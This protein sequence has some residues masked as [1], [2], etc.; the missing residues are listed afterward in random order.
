[1]FFIINRLWSSKLFRDVFYVM[2]RQFGVKILSFCALTYS[3]RVLGPSEIGLAGLALG[4]I[5][6]LGFVTQLGLDTILPQNLSLKSSDVERNV[7]AARLYSM[8]LSIVLMLSPVLVVGIFY[9]AGNIGVEFYKILSIWTAAF[10]LMVANALNPQLYIQGLGEVRSYSNIQL[11]VSVCSAVAIGILSFASPSIDGLNFLQSLAILVV[12]YL[13]Y[14]KNKLIGLVKVGWVSA[15]GV[16]QHVR[17]AWPVI[18]SGFAIYLIGG[19]EVLIMPMVSTVKQVG[20]YNGGMAI[21]AGVNAFL[22]LA[23]FV[24]YP[25]LLAWNKIGEGFAFNRVQLIAVG[26]LIIS[27]VFYFSISGV[28]NKY[29]LAFM[30]QDFAGVGTV[31]VACISQFISYV[32]WYCVFSFFNINSRAKLP[33][34]ITLAWA[35][36]AVP[37]YVFASISGGAVGVAFSKA[38]VYYGILVTALLCLRWHRLSSKSL[39]SGL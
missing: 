9:Q 36:L 28:F 20:V 26:M 29:A 2:L 3:M 27:P 10:G 23:T 33:L 31:I 22:G 24:L 7:E 35:C 15:R 17:S 11:L 39:T 6:V 14:K 21:G 37:L 25:R 19:V 4:T 5:S 16:V 34:I 8:R 30:G 13:V 12:V 32:G 38:I 1:M 18:S